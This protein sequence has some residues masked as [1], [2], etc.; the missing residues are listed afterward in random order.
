[1]KRK[2][3]YTARRKLA[4]KKKHNFDIG[5]IYVIALLLFFGLIAIYDAT[6]I[7]AQD[8]YGDAYRF[9]YLQSGWIILGIFAFF[10]FFRINLQVLRR[11]SIGIFAVAIV[12]LSTLA[13]FGTMECTTDFIFAPCINGAN[14]WFYFN[15]P[16]MPSL[17]IVGV[18]GFQPSELTKF[19]L[20]LFL[21]AYIDKAVKTGKDFF[22][23]FSLI[24]GGVFLLV[25][26]QPNLSTALLLLTV[27][28]TMYF[29]SGANIKTLLTF[30][31]L[32]ALF[33]GVLMFSSE[34]RRARLATFLSSGGGDELTSGYHIKQILIALGSGGFFGVGFGQSRQ[35]FQYLPEVFADSIFAVIGE[36]L[37]FMGT[38][39][40]VILFSL[41]IYKGFTIAKEAR[42]LYGKLLAVGV[43]TWIGVQFC[44]NV[45]AMTK[46]IPLTGMP[47]PLISYGGSSLIFIMMGL[48]VLANISR[49]G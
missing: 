42:S 7:L 6:V 5:L 16:P 20:V 45:A 11:I 27:G 23:R 47:L 12:F 30:G 10:I 40:L 21:A 44:V 4:P 29:S 8:L 31:P 35:K 41:L 32:A 18:L 33:G 15:P 14:R 36:E 34:Y 17:P 48:G 38:S 13:L 46:L 22:V 26:L 19:A 3:V 2:N 28:F 43:T 24:V 9:V 49:R 25:I 1:M 39:A 37:G